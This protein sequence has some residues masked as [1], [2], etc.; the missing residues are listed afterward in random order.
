MKAFVNAMPARSECWV[1][2]AGPLAAWMPLAATLLVNPLG[3]GQQGVQQVGDLALEDSAEAAIPVDTPAIRIVLLIPEAMPDRA[4][5]DPA[6]SR[7]S[8]GWRARCRCRSR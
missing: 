3:A 5:D 6:R 2:E 1:G 8:T 7:R 4:A